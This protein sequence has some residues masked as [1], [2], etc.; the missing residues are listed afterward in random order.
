M[1]YP[2][3]SFVQPRLSEDSLSKQ[4]STC[5]FNEWVLRASTKY[6]NACSNWRLGLF[7]REKREIAR[8]E[9]M[10]ISCWRGN[11]ISLHVALCCPMLLHIALYCS[12]IGFGQA[13]FGEGPVCTP[14]LLRVACF[15][16]FPF[17]FYARSAS[18]P[19]HLLRCQ[20]LFQCP[21]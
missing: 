21:A 2:K 8:E 18:F 12:I 19:Y 6:I 10:V 1:S 15:P 13:T 11:S 20:G 7:R 3:C 16:L 4:A 9:Q 17:S 5:S 14:S